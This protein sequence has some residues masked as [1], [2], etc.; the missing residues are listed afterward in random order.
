MGSPNAAAHCHLLFG[1]ECFPRAPLH[2]HLLL[3]CNGTQLPTPSRQPASMQRRMRGNR[4]Y[5]P[6]PTL[7]AAVTHMLHSTGMWV[8]GCISLREFVL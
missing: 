5:L 8:S 1:K 7:L 2:I 4:S 3:F 6:R